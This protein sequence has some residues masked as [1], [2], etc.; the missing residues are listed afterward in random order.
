MGR[1]DVLLQRQAGNQLVVVMPSVVVIFPP[2]IAV[3]TMIVPVTM[4]V[5]GVELT[6]AGNV[7]V[8]I[9]I[10]P[11][12]VDPLAAGI[13]FVA[14][15]FPMPGMARGDVQINWR[16]VHRHSFDYHRLPINQGGPR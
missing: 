10:V 13:I 12:E 6:I 16:T 7:F 15:P 3:M 1:P 11:H 5:I 2:L 4:L 9:P 8:A 14:V